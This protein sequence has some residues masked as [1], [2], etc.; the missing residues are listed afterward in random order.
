MVAHSADEGLKFF[1]V[2][3]TFQVRHRRAQI[4]E[5]TDATMQLAELDLLRMIFIVK[6]Q[7]EVTVEEIIQG[8]NPYGAVHPIGLLIVVPVFQRQGVIGVRCNV[9]VGL[10]CRAMHDSQG[11]VPEI[12]AL[13]QYYYIQLTGRTTRFGVACVM[14]SNAL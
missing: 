14:L 5:K 11:T 2:G 6:H 4:I 3:L 13:L 9:L 8:T 7:C 10:I 1:S 12:S